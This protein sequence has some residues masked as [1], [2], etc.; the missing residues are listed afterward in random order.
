MP[1]NISSANQD[2]L[3]AQ[4][5]SARDF[6]TII[7]RNRSTGLPVDENLWSDVGNITAAVVDPDTGADDNR[8]FYGSGNL[9]RISAITLTSNLTVQQVSIELSLISDKVAEIFRTYDCQQARVQI[10][11]GLYNPET[12][13]MVDAAENRFDGFVDSIEVNTPADGDEGTVTLNCVSH[14]QELTRSNPDT[15]SHESQIRRLA[16]DAFYRDS[17]TVSEWEFFW[18]SVKGKVQTVKKKKFLGIF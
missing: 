11:R 17:A 2:L 5:L 15:R 3:E 4:V 18:G 8:D 12:E 6:L 16:A 1:R 10:F 13:L 9:V 14:S 7:A